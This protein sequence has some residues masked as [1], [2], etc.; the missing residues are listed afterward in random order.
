MSIRKILA[1]SIVALALALTALRPQPVA[2][3]V[4][5]MECTGCGAESGCTLCKASC[6]NGWDHC[7]YACGGATCSQIEP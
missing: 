4:Q 1:L 2:A 6:I 7:T 5:Y 3:S